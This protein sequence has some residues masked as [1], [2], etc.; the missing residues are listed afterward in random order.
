M[1]HLLHL[2]TVLVLNRNWQAI[3]VKTPAEAF[4]M[5]ASGSATGL[6]VQGDDHIIP[7]SW[8]GWLT[9]PVREDDIPTSIQ[10]IVHLASSGQLRFAG[11]AVSRICDIPSGLS[12]TG[13]HWQPTGHPPT[14]PT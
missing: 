6:D 9:L 11:S 7:V 3:H 2:S 8:E 13:A 12:L 1:K 4:C 5:M 14:C 10:R